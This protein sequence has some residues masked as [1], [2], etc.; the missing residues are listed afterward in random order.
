MELIITGEN[1]I[2]ENIVLSNNTLSTA[3]PLS[4]CFFATSYNPSSDADI[5]AKSIHICGKDS[6]FVVKIA[7]LLPLTFFSSMGS[8][9]STAHRLEKRR[10]WYLYYFDDKMVQEM[11][12]VLLGKDSK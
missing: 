11:R 7:Q 6:N 8:T 2:V 10:A 5:N 9:A 3:L 12:G 4:D 1:S